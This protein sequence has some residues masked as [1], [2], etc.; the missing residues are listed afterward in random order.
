[1]GPAVGTAA[2]LAGWAWAGESPAG[3]LAAGLAT[4]GGTSSCAGIPY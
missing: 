1:M 2:G 4:G 3:A